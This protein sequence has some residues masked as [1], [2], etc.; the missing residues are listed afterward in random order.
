[1]K[2]TFFSNSLR[3]LCLPL[4]GAALAIPFVLT[5]QAQVPLDPYLAGLPVEQRIMQAPVF[6]NPIV[7]IGDQAP[8]PAESATCGP[9][10]M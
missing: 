7:Y 1:M 8:D 10:S 5:T 4:A 6:A 9:P 2:T 3:V